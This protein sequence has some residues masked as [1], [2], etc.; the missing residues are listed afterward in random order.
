MSFKQ[1]AAVVAVLF[2]FRIATAQ[3]NNYVKGVAAFSVQEF[4][5]AIPLLRPYADAGDCYAEYAVGFALWSDKTD[6]VN[7]AL[8]ERYLT[9]A[10]EHKQTHAMGVL[11]TILIMK[12]MNDPSIRPQALMW[13]ELAAMYDP[14]QVGTTTRHMIRQYLEAFEIDKAEELIKEKQKIFDGMQG[15]EVNEALMK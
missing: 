13:A 12:S 4:K 11:A 14:I 10:A 1:I 9:R 8:A 6:P 7:D 5:K 15:C 2:T 3:Q